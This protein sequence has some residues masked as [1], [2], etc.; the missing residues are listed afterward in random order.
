[1]FSAEKNFRRKMFRPKALSAEIVFGRRSLVEQERSLV[2]TRE[3]SRVRTREISGRKK[4]SAQ[5]V[6]GRKFFGRKYFRPKKFSTENKFDRNN[7]RPKN[8]WPKNFSG[9]TFFGRKT[10]R[11]FEDFSSKSEP[12][13]FGASIS[14][15]ALIQFK[16]V[17]TAL[18]TK[19]TNQVHISQ[20]QQQRIDTLEAQ[21]AGMTKQVNTLN[22][23][24]ER[25]RR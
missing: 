19:Y 18:G 25:R 20:M 7:F 21:L 10:F 15:T 22:D 12:V 2:P 23:D 11:P 9:E 8:F 16:N 14:E 13:F 4:N 3:I 1:M 17:L 6:F 24:D 5:K